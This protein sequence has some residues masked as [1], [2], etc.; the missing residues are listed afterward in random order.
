LWEGE[1][2]WRRAGVARRRRRRCRRRNSAHTQFCGQIFFRKN[3]NNSC[4]RL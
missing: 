2:L 1:N 4:T 3:E